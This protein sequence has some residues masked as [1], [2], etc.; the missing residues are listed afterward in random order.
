[1]PRPP[2]M[3]GLPTTAGGW[4]ACFRYRLK[5]TKGLPSS[6]EQV[7]ADL[8]VSGDTMRRW[9]TDRAI[10]TDSDL[11]RFAQKCELTATEESF[12]FKAFAPVN[13]ESG[14]NEDA[15]RR[16]TAQVLALGIPAYL[17]DSLFYVRA[18]NS[19]IDLVYD[20][21]L[22]PQGEHIVE[23][24]LEDPPRYPQPPNLWSTRQERAEWW[25][26]DFWYE[27]AQ[28]CG[29]VPYQRVIERLA[30]NNPSF[31]E[32]W[33]GLG[34]LHRPAGE[35]PIGSPKLRVDPERG[36]YML[37]TSAVLIPPMYFLHVYCPV[38]EIA[39]ERL[40]LRRSLGEA[41]V[42]TSFLLHWSE[43]GLDSPTDPPA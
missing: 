11:R 3:P 18:W 17:Y 13:I 38:D 31:V 8:G 7:A 39:W 22:E 2:T 5:T 30:V 41:R 36:T 33:K 34:L 6:P 19:Y 40:K 32:R 21:P 20:R 35:L 12:L 1:M 9:E 25:L 28:M 42:E 27:T 26:R 10:P 29:S 37:L 24:V 4:L 43:A 14:P 23:R 16:M 15:F